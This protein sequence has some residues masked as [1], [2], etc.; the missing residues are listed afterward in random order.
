M[1]RH[2]RWLAG[3]LMAGFLLGGGALL[4]R[5]GIYGLTLFILLP[6][7]LGGLGAWSVRAQAA[8]IAVVAGGRAV[9][10]ASIGLLALGQEGALCIAMSLPL[11]LPLGWLGGF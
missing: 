10:L 7:I 9:L 8:D 11:S 5:S 2:W 4:L 1:S 6:V 3:L